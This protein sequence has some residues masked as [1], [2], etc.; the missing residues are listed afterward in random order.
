MI[1]ILVVPCGVTPAMNDSTLLRGI[2]YLPV[3]LA[4]TPVTS[5]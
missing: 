5:M 2:S 4:P 1:S 3:S